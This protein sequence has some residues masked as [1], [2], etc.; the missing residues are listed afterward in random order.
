[1]DD[2]YYAPATHLLY[3]GAAKAS[4]LTIARTDDKGHLALVAQVPT[5]E[6]ARNG[7]LAQNGTLY[8]AHSGLTK[9]SA[10]I[11]VSPSGK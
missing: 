9:L 7:V 6:G 3:V 4:K 5:R 8:M 1:V 11:V 2:I 10:L